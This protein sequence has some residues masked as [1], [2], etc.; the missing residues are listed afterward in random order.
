MASTASPAAFLA[1][2]ALAWA[3]CCCRVAARLLARGLALCLRLLCH[4]GY[5]PRIGPLRVVLPGR[6]LAHRD[7]HADERAGAALVVGDVDLPHPRR[8]AAV[9]AARG[10]VDRAV[11]DRAQE[12]RLVGEALRALPS[13]LTAFAVANE[14]RLSAIDGV[15]AAVDQPGGLE[16]SRRGPRPGRVASSSPSERISSP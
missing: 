2:F 10:R 15:D 16:D 5:L 9:A 13:A 8:A 3:S 7:G 6:R 14:V 11:E 1:S 12:A 4:L